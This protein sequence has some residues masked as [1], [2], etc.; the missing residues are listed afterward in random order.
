[1]S[2]TFKHKVKMSKFKFFV[3]YKDLCATINPSSIED[4]KEGILSIQMDKYKIIIIIT[5]NNQCVVEIWE[6]KHVAAQPARLKI[7]I[8]MSIKI[9]DLV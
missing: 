2:M 8:L 1:M 5:K 6:N 9:V 7:N 3:K 4:L